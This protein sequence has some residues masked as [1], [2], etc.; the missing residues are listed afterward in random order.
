MGPSRR[1]CQGTERHSAPPFLLSTGKSHS[2]PRSCLWGAATPALQAYGNFWS[3][4]A[5][6]IK[7]LRWAEFISLH[8]NRSLASWSSSV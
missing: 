4:S 8:S 7:R 5:A 2:P 3:D 1:S 6:F